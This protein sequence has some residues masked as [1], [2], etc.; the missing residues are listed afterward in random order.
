M[1]LYPDIMLIR[2]DHSIAVRDIY[3]PTLEYIIDAMNGEGYEQHECDGVGLKENTH[4]ITLFPNP[5]NESLTLKGESL[6]TVRVFNAL[7]QQVD[8]LEADGEELSIN[9]ARYENGV[10]V[11]KAGERALRFVVRH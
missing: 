2:P 4:A 6:G 9:T 7:G 5:A 11:I 3:P 10:F 8:V 1:G